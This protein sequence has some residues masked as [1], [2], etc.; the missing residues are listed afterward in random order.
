MCEQQFWTHFQRH[1]FFNSTQST[2]DLILFKECETDQSQKC[3]IF[4]FPY[5]SI[6]HEHKKHIRNNTLS[7]QYQI[8]RFQDHSVTN[9]S[10]LIYR[11]VTLY[12]Y[13]YDL[14][15]TIRGNKRNGNIHPSFIPITHRKNHV[16]I[17]A[18]PKSDIS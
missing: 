8:I 17:Q 7:G 13:N 9:Q 14:K 5:S 16:L 12:G 4:T 6:S 18:S 15:T 2:N 1:M 10:V 11:H 3:F